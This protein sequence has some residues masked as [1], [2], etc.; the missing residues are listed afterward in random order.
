MK[1]LASIILIFVYVSVLFFPN[2]MKESVNMI[3]N[4][5]STIGIAILFYAISK[6]NKHQIT[7]Y[8]TVAIFF[9]YMAACFIIYYTTGYKTG[10]GVDLLITII[11]VL[12]ILY[13]SRWRRT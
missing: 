10:R 13:H 12:C 5:L 1:K 7:E 8:Y 4:V 11:I 9:A 6:E 3:Y 2:S